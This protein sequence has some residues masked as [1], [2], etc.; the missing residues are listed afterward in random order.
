MQHIVDILTTFGWILLAIWALQTLVAL[1]SLRA[2]R[3]LEFFR[4][5]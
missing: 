5:R 2:S 3:S 4:E 1:V